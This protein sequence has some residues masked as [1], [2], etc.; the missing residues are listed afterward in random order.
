MF[1]ISNIGVTIKK[2]IFIRDRSSSLYYNINRTIITMMKKIY[3]LSLVSKVNFQVLISEIY[4]ITLKMY[5]VEVVDA[6]SRILC[7]RS[8]QVKAV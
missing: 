7:C 3:K 8:G 4:K 6:Q 2:S 1:S 5:S